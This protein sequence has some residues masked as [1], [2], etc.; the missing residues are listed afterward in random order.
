LVGNAYKPCHLSVDVWCL[1]TL[2]T[3]NNGFEK[4]IVL[5]VTQ[6]DRGVSLMCNKV[7]PHYVLLGKQ[8]TDFLLNHKMLSRQLITIKQKWNSL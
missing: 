2:V 3:R 1:K 4:L 7:I 6:P 8:D 5:C